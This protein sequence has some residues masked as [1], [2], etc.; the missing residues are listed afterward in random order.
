MTFSLF[1]QFYKVEL[2]IF[3]NNFSNYH[4]NIKFT[5]EFDKERISFLNLEVSLSGGHF[6]ID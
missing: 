6:T 3:L 2:V 5:H 1:G 4:P